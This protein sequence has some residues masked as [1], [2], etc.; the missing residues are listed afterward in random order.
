MPVFYNHVGTF[1]QL[2]LKQ[3]PRAKDREPMFSENQWTLKKG[4]N[5]NKILN[6]KLLNF[7][8]HHVKT[9]NSEFNL[10]LGLN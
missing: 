3:G 7:V 4:T 1:L 8:F 6:L 2:E 5:E 10:G 9:Q